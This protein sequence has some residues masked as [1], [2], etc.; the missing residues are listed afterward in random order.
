M[1]INRGAIP[2]PAIP[3]RHRGARKPAVA[4]NNPRPRI[5][6]HITP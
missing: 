4:T 1:T 2:L 6:Q 3:T 5:A